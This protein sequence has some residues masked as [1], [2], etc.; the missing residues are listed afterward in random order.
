MG[1]ARRGG[2]R[3][4]LITTDA[5]LDCAFVENALNFVALK[6]GRALP[7]PLA[8]LVVA[9]FGDGSTA[10][11]INPLIRAWKLKVPHRGL[12]GVTAY[13]APNIRYFTIPFNA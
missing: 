13:G 9:D 4:A 8:P 6:I 11:A 12:N 3:R 2:L 7:P 5:N 10:A 1:R